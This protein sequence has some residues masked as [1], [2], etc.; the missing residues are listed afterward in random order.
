[1]RLAG[2]VAAALA[3]ACCVA[4][5][6]PAAAEAVTYRG[7]TG[8][9]SNAGVVVDSQGITQRVTI[10]WT[11]RCGQFGV[12]WKDATTV[13]GPFRSQSSLR[14][15]GRYRVRSGRFTGSIAVRLRATKVSA[16]RWKG[17]F[18]AS[19][20]VRRRGKVIDRCR[21][22]TTRWRAT[23]PQIRLTVNSEPGDYIFQGGSASY[24]SPQ[25]ALG[26][27]GNKSA[28]TV[29]LP[30]YSIDIRAP[31]RGSLRPGRYTGAK[32]ASFAEGAPGIDFSGDGRG[33]NQV[34]GEFTIHSSSFDRRG[35]VR[36]IN[37]SFD[38]RCERSDAPAL[39]GALFFRR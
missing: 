27:T 37:L 21:M 3:S 38:H 20:V 34:A 26:V 6:T 39:R 30:K 1:M 2:G 29:T 13:P 12:R 25:D 11:A 18:K 9:G 16:F 15:A 4:V 32:R 14:E 7:T 8:Q 24:A 36:A 35:E 17:T 19:V 31:R 23:I 10:A 22:G 33:C 5:M 28:I